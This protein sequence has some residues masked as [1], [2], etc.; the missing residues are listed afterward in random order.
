MPYESAQRDFTWLALKADAE[1]KFAIALHSS[2]APFAPPATTRTGMSASSQQD[3]YNHTVMLLTPYSL[4]PTEFQ[5]K[6]GAAVGS[7]RISFV[8]QL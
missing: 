6:S 4:D 3:V 1:A 7:A 2:L 5:S 8:R